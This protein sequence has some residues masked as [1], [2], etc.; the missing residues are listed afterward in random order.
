MDAD[1]PLEE[2]EDT[3]LRYAKTKAL[4]DTEIYRSYLRLVIL[5]AVKAYNS[6]PSK[7]QREKL[8]DKAV[9]ILKRSKSR[10]MLTSRLRN[11][12]GPGIHL[13]QP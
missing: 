5:A 6:K 13:T 2:Q 12:G 8:Q 4:Y 11:R 7:G 9:K 3:R 1:E 10:E